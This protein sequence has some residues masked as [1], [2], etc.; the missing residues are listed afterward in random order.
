MRVSVLGAHSLWELK[1]VQIFAKAEHQHR[2]HV[3]C[4]DTRMGKADLRILQPA[5]S[6]RFVEREP[7]V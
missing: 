4:I 1:N 2:L 7:G 6:Y 3:W 5:Q